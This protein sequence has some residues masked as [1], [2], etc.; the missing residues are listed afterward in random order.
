MLFHGLLAMHETVQDRP[1]P[2]E[3]RELS[4]TMDW[5]QANA[6]KQAERADIDL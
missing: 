1:S 5:R 4:V 3:C 2:E 6:E